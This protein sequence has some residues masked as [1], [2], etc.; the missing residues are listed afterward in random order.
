LQVIASALGVQPPGA[1]EDGEA[2]AR[3][4]ARQSLG[5]SPSSRGVSLTDTLRRSLNLRSHS[6]EKYISLEMMPPAAAVPAV[7]LTPDK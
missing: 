2:D 3:I 6:V 7:Q 1:D 5:A 4:M